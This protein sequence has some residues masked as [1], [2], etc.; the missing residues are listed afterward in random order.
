MFLHI[1]LTTRTLMY[2][3]VSTSLFW[4]TSIQQ[5]TRMRPGAPGRQRDAAPPPWLSA[6]RA[7][8]AHSYNELLHRSDWEP[9]SEPSSEQQ[10]HRDRTW[11][12]PAPP[13]RSRMPGGKRGLVAP[14]NTFLE[15]IVRRSSGECA[16]ERG[17]F[18]GLVSSGGSDPDSAGIFCLYKPG[19][20]RRFGG[21]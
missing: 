4:G 3:A 19:K 18:W 21:G 17:W 15:N 12:T 20:P 14:Q 6:P 2:S 10:T 8:R 9:A 16:P 5:Q 1:S 13:A 7:A 11:P